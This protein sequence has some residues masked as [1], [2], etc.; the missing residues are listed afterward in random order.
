MFEKGNKYLIEQLQF[1]DHLR[2]DRTCRKEYEIIKMH[3]SERYKNNKHQYADDKTLFVKSV[4][5]KITQ[6]K[7]LPTEF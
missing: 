2:N 6:Q 4:F 7:S 3:L 5:N 1:R